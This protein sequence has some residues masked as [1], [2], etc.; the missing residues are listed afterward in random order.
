M[1]MMGCGMGGMGWWMLV[2]GLLGLGL[3][4]L[5]IVGTV[6]L[7]RGAT[8]SSVGTVRAPGAETPEELLR[9]R[10]AAGEIAEDEFLRRMSGL[11]GWS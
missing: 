9:R 8:S 4:V 1:G 5:L 6:W 10:Y 2:P 3:L 7:V 11:S